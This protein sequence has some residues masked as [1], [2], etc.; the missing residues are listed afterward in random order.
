MSRVPPFACAI[1]K[2]SDFPKGN[3]GTDAPVHGVCRR[4]APRIDSY[5]QAQ[6]PTVTHLDWCG[7]GRP[8]EKDGGS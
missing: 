2:F 8:R 6:W 7:D 3:F 4:L 5:G 1:C